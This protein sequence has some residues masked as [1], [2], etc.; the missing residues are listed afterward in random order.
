MK[1]DIDL[2]GAGGFFTQIADEVLKELLSTIVFIVSLYLFACLLFCAQVGNEYCGS[3]MPVW[4][5]P[6]KL[7]AACFS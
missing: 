1:S 7:F 3:Y 4:H 2:N 5:W 6:F